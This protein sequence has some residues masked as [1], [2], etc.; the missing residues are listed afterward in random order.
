MT[1]PT[2][3]SSITLRRKY[4]PWQPLD[5]RSGGSGSA[6]GVIDNSVIVKWSLARNGRTPRPGWPDP[7]ASIPTPAA[8]NHS[9]RFSLMISPLL[10]RDP[11]PVNS[12]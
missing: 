12:S 3:F 7:G 4:G 1:P 10:A 9:R 8:P 11:D 5:A 2:V 6:I